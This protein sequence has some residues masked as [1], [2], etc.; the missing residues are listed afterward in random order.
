M[1]TNNMTNEPDEIEALLPWHAAGT[2][3]PPMRAGSR[4]HWRA[5]RIWPSVMRGA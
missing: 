5:I 1:K 3:S 4:T 2:L